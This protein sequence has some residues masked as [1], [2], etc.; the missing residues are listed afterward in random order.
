MFVV[1]LSR[2]EF[3]LKNSSGP[4]KTSQLNATKIGTFAALYIGFPDSTTI[5]VILKSGLVGKY[6]PIGISISFNFYIIIF[7]FSGFG[8][9]GFNI[10]EI[11]V[12]Y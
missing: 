5:E 8:I 4:S 6:M 9:L 12:I 1:R 7:F 11:W 2:F 3:L 10:P